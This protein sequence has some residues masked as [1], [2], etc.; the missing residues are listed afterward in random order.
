MD[1]WMTVVKN[2]TPSTNPRPYPY[3]QLSATD[4]TSTAADSISLIDPYYK[5]SK[6]PSAWKKLV[7]MEKLQVSSPILKILKIQKQL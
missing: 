3:Q 7:G 6:L 5:V 2:N 1:E 4:Y